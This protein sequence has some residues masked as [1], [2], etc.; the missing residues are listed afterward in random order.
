LLDISSALLAAPYDLTK[1]AS[2]TSQKKTL[3][4]DA[5]ALRVKLSQDEIA[6]LLDSR[7]GEAF[8]LEDLTVFARMLFRF[9]QWDYCLPV[10]RQSSLAGSYP[11]WLVKGSTDS[12]LYK[13][14]TI[15]KC[16]ASTS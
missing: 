4:D 8:Q 12:A 3:V 10:I 13:I 6:V 9:G 15:V 16:N 11:Y 2:L 7:R 5:T 1:L 14:E